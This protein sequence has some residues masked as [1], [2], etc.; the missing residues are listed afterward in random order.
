VAVIDAQGRATPVPLP[1]LHSQG[2]PT[3][4]RPSF[5]P[6][7]S[8]F[9]Y[10]ALDAIWIA[11]TN[12]TEDR[13]VAAGSA[14]AWSPDG[15]TIA[16]VAP[17]RGRLGNRE[18]G[19]WLMSAR[20]GKTLRRIWRHS[21]NSLDWSPAGGRLVATYT[22]RS[23]RFVPTGELFTLDAKRGTARRIDVRGHF[24]E[25]AAAWSPDGRRIAFELDRG[26]YSEE[27][28]GDLEQAEIW[29]IGTS[30]ERPTRI[31]KRPWLFEP[32]EPA[33]LSWQPRPR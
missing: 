24:V 6:D 22:V 25:R 4:A 28:D 26:G 23:P 8:H 7:G 32:A 5:A 10:Q 12:G 31:W 30:G 13:M 33:G 21:A 27:A 15:R 20:T 11:S 29:T 18:G 14:P 1:V 17:Q 3:R 19:T 9:A 2:I 16:Y